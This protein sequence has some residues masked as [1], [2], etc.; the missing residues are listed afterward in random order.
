L[1]RKLSNL[2]IALGGL[3]ILLIGAIWLRSRLAV[4]QP[5]DPRYLTS[6]VRVGA[7]LP[8]A[9]DVPV[10]PVSQSE[11]ESP[12]AET[13]TIDTGS[14]VIRVVIPH[15]AVDQSVIPVGLRRDAKSGIVWDSDV[16]F[17][18]DNRRDLVGQL[19]ISVNPGE[20]GNII[21]IGH[22]YNGEL[23]NWEGV[24]LHLGD[25]QPGNQIVLYTRDGGKYVYAVQK[26]EK[27]PSNAL[28]TH[29]KNLWPTPF[30][31]LTLVTCGGPNYGRWSIRVYAFAY[32]I[33]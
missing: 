24:F 8:N 14:P 6:R 25:L 1:L 21:L 4:E 5:T 30:E 31:Q 18:T 26:L 17:S 11:T 19:I 16:L 15:I 13:R 2:L 9:A 7:P 23:Y 22:N 3:L 32:P 20:G 27:V 33:K 12:A 10:A 29:E 28:T